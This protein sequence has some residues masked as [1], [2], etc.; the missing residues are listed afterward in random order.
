MTKE[1]KTEEVVKQPEGVSLED[2]TIDQLKVAAFDT[3]QNIKALQRNL[4]TIFNEL[5]KKLEETK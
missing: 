4:Q 1:E 2:A 3:E 5:Q